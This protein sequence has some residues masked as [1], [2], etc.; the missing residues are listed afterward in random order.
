MVELLT[1][2]QVSKIRLFDFFS[3]VQMLEQIFTKII[4][5][6]VINKC[7]TKAIVKGFFPSII[8]KGWRN[9]KILDERA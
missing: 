7:K 1:K 6:I 4:K 8:L 5:S 2:N 9:L 3:N